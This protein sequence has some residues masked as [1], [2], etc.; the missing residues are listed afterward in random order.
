MPEIEIKAKPHIESKLKLLKKDFSVVYD[1]VYGPSTSGFGWD[2]ITKCVVAEAPIWEEYIKSHKRAANFRHKEIPHFEALYTIY[3]KDQ[4]NGSNAQD[5]TD[6][7][8]EMKNE[9][10]INQSDDSG[11]VT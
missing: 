2:P 6:V 11:Y 1:M 7:I 5:P 8:E 9:E 10:V 3:G 4:A